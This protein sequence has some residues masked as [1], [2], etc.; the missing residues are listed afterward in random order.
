MPN[1]LQ[2]DQEQF[3]MEA[4]DGDVGTMRN[5]REKEKPEKS[6]IFGH[7]SFE[8]DQ[9]RRRTK[10]TGRTRRRKRETYYSSETDYDGRHSDSDD[11]NSSCSEETKSDDGRRKARIKVK[12]V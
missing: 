1:S 8:G 10:Q 6:R 3:A 9:S 11:S 5:S 2:I 7:A 4:R 12:R